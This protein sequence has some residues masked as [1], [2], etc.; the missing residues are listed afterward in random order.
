MEYQLVLQ[1]KTGQNSDFDDLVDLED[2]LEEQLEGIAEI[3]GHDM[4]RSEMNLFIITES[5][6]KTFEVT[7]SVVEKSRFSNNFKAAYRDLEGEEFT[8]LWPADLKE[9]SVQ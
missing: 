9:F 8:I 2:V 7:K 1:L 5:P 3:D 6:G 4:G